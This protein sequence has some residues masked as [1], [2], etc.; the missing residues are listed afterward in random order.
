MLHASGPKRCVALGGMV[1][2]MKIALLTG[3]GREGQVGEAVAARLA[4]DGYELILVG[5]NAT[6]VEAR[7]ESIR[8]SG[9]KASAYSADL[10][11]A[12][13]VTAL[14]GQVVSRHG[15]R[16]DALVHL[17]GGFASTGPVAETEVTAWDRQLSINLQTAFLVAR[18]AIPRLRPA[19][20]SLVFFS[21]E[22]A[23]SGAKLSHI[24]AYAVAKSGLL[25]LSSAISQ[26]ERAHGV[27]SNVV[28]PAAIR[29]ATNVQSMPAGSAF[30]ER[31]DVAATVS[32]LC[33]DAAAAVT[34]QILRLTP[35]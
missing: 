15:E 7:A 20:G 12:A 23:L 16:L 26:E 8:S 32:W 2:R 4:A 35:R 30:V 27:R 24:A 21:S 19:R 18:S 9:M 11:D 28:A 22:L 29:T 6:S 3:V 13:A 1:V 33:S 31:D 25:A 14:F 5:R 17:A 10:S 34:G